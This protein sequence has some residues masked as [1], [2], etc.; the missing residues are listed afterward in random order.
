MDLQVNH[1]DGI[2]TNNFVSNLEW[3]TAS[4]QMRHADLTGLRDLK[5]SN[6]SQSKLTEDK[7]REIKTLILANNLTLNAISKMYGVTLGS[8]SAIKRNK[9]WAHIPWPEQKED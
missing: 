1:K 3:A 4:E 2:K 9:T 5:G 8:I 6:N 7:V